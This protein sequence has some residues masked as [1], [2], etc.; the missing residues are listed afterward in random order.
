MTNEQLYEAGGLVRTSA[1]ASGTYG[2]QH[3]ALAAVCAVSTI[4]VDFAAK[5]AGHAADAILNADYELYSVPFY[6]RERQTETGEWTH[7]KA[8]R[9][10]RRWQWRRLLAYL[11]GEVP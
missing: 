7:M 1:G 6:G 3:A 2:G 8:Y 9:E 10:E 11:R 4:D 5:S